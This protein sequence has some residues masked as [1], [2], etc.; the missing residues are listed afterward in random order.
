MHIQSETPIKLVVDDGTLWMSIPFAFGFVFLLYQTIHRAIIH[1][2]NR[3]DIL[4]PIIMGLFAYASAQ[5]TR[6]VFNAMERRVQWWR[7]QYLR[8]RSDSLSF[9]E[10]TDI[11]IETI[12]T[13]KG[14]KAHRL[15]IVTRQTRIPMS[16][17]TSGIGIF[18]KMQMR[19][20]EFVMGVGAAT[21]KA[22]T[23]P[24]DLTSSIQ[25]LL[26]QGRK[27]EAIKLLHQSGQYG[28]AEATSLVDS[29]EAGMKAK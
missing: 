24:D 23:R 16:N 19:I 13:D 2:G 21:R 10:I 9:D 17:G 15:A 26:A 7:F 1:T 3:W 29:M 28:L 12:T 11:A 20:M 25:S 6:F 14:G 22:A 8:V 27:V 18:E 5:H 4:A